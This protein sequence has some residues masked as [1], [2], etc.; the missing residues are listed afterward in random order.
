MSKGS[1]IPAIE[2]ATGFSWDSWVEFFSTHDAT[3]L[4]HPDIARLA[5]KR[6]AAALEN[7]DWWAQS[8]AVIY[9]Q[10]IGRRLPG[11]AADGSFQF[12]I[13]RT[14]PANLD[15]ALQQ[16]RQVVQTQSNFNGRTATGEPRISESE[17]W[18]YWRVGLE[19]GTA[20]S[21]DIGRKGEKS[22]L[23][24]NHRKIQDPEQV[25]VWQDYWRSLLAILPEQPTL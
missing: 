6:L 15:I 14:V 12:S 3:T 23:T 24:V 10:H 4:P 9:E 8:V 7:P 25:P 11:Q 13:S 20:V 5:K 18:R 19:D 22:S 17:K 21:V 16:W 2:R 1:K